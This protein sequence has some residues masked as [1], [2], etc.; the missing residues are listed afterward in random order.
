MENE[1]KDQKNK[2]MNVKKVV[3]GFVE[4][5]VDKIAINTLGRIVPSFVTPNMMTAFGA[6]GGL[7]GIV[8]AF[9]AKLLNLSDDVRNSSSVRQGRW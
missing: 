4:K 2:D 6:L 9:L 3:H 1:N 7:F 8:C 5:L